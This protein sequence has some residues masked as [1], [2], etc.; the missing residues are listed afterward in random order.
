MKIED[1]VPASELD[2]GI[3]IDLASQRL[4]R[5]VDPFTVVSCL[6]GCWFVSGGQHYHYL[7]DG[8]GT[9]PASV[10]AALCTCDEGLCEITVPH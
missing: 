10:Q 9:W 6:P 8:S 3:V 7:A 4:T 2:L 1:F 5:G